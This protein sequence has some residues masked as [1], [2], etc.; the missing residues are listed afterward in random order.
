[1]KPLFACSKQAVTTPREGGVNHGHH[2]AKLRVPAL[3]KEN[4]TAVREAILEERRK[5]QEALG[6]L[7]QALEDARKAAPVAQVKVSDLMVHVNEETALRAD[8]EGRLSDDHARL[9]LWGSRS[10]HR[11]R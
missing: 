10:K 1:M 6:P 4:Q 2:A 7:K 9:R 8:L 3:G 5:Q 11:K